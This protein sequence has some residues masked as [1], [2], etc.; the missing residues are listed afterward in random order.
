[1]KSTAWL[2]VLVLVAVV[3][4]TGFSWYLSSPEWS[5]LQ[6]LIHLEC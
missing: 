1:M 4:A 5:S 2:P 3:L 6:N